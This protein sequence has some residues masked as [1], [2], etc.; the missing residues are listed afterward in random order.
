MEI[1]CTSCNTLSS[2]S[3]VNPSSRLIISSFTEVCAILFTHWSPSLKL[4]VLHFVEM[5]ITSNKY[6]IVLKRNGCNPNIVVRY[7]PPPEF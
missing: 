7:G 1:V 2:S 6:Q 3:N 4:Q 5:R